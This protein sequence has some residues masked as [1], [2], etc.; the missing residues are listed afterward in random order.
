MRERGGV[1]KKAKVADDDLSGPASCR[2]EDPYVRDESGGE[3]RYAAE[4][5][6]M[7]WRAWVEGIICWKGSE[8]GKA[9]V[10]DFSHLA[11]FLLNLCPAPPD[12]IAF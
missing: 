4:E 9:W 12:C 5:E 3:G 2:A 6:I 7:V 10:V 8:G 11:L 1:L